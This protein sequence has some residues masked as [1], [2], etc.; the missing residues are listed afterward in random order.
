MQPENLVTPRQFVVKLERGEN[1]LSED[2]FAKVQNNAEYINELI[3][4]IVEHEKRD[5]L[6]RNFACL[7]RPMRDVLEA[8]IRNDAC[9]SDSGG[10]NIVFF[11]GFLVPLFIACLGATYSVVGSLRLSERE[12]ELQRGTFEAS[13]L[14]EIAVGCASMLAGVISMISLA[15]W[16]EKRGYRK[17]LVT[18]TRALTSPKANEVSTADQPGSRDSFPSSM[19]EGATMMIINYEGDRDGDLQRNIV[20][21]LMPLAK[22]GCGFKTYC[23]ATVPTLQT[24]EPACAMMEIDHGFPGPVCR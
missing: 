17:R 3:Q 14:K 12:H 19:L 16:R 7:A 21:R 18:L 20:N 1:P 2:Q 22:S 11:A 10:F 23:Q 9:S 8:R 4:A 13:G 24:D 5:I 15:V 6:L